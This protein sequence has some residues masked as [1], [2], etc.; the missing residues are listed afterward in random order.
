MQQRYDFLL[1]KFS[2]VSIT[3]ETSVN[4]VKKM[5]RRYRR[6]GF[7]S[8]MRISGK[9]GAQLAR[10]T[11][12]RLTPY[13][14]PVAA[15]AARYAVSRLRGMRFGMSK[16]GRGGATVV[17]FGN[18]GT[19]MQDVKI[20]GGDNS[21]SKFVRKALKIR[22]FKKRMMQSGPMR[23]FKREQTTVIPFLYGRQA[24]NSFT[25][26]TASQLDIISD[27]VTTD[28]TAKILMLNTVVK[29]EISNGSKAACKLKIYEGVFKRD[30][31]SAYNP[32]LL[33]S[34][35]LGATGSTQGVNGI[36]SIPFQ[37]PN[38]NAFCHVTRI[39]NVYL[40]Q[41]RTHE[42][43]SVYNYNRLYDKSTLAGAPSVENLRGWSR[44]MM[45]A[46]YGEPVA[47]STGTVVTTASGKLLMVQTQTTRYKYNLPETYKTDYV[48]SIPVTGFTTERLID[49]G[50]GEAE[51]NVVL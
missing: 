51:A 49:E 27:T 12:R 7:I 4:S 46:A 18:S 31:L 10:S 39:Y 28:A 43:T 45:I 35:G 5:V 8:G 1:R 34:D 33:W 32:A 19:P 15:A 30:T 40:P 50:S 36:Q 44:F 21:R 25:Y 26:N 48:R 17:G 37:S 9:S 42:H 6:A 13:A 22:G 47:D 14:A 24:V 11:A 16:R 23:A 41:G 3:L 38:F 2:K 29:Y 20:I